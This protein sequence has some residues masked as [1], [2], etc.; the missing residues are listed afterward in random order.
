M[1]SGSTRLAADFLGEQRDLLENIPETETLLG[2]TEE[3]N[4]RSLGDLEAEK[5]LV[6]PEGEQD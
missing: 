6:V 2:V 1:T 3:E 5:L 4:Q